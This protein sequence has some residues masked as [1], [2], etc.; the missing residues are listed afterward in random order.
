MFRC[1]VVHEKMQMEWFCK[2]KAWSDHEA[3]G[4]CLIFSMSGSTA[5]ECDDIREPP[6]WK[7]TILKGKKNDKWHQIK[8]GDYRQL[9]Q[10]QK[11][12][13]VY[14]NDLQQWLIR[15]EKHSRQSTRLC[16]VHG[17]LTLV[18]QNL[19]LINVLEVAE[20]WGILLR[21]LY[22]HN[23]YVLLLTCLHT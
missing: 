9:L 20:G 6:Q 18:P 13:A 16:M 21:I 17:G 11:H 19:V 14:L 7:K 22:F 12:K 4:G 15:L 10:H 1:L 8:K 23:F 2:K 5:Y 3:G